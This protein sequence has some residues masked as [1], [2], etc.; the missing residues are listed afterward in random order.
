MK[1]WHQA[2]TALLLV[3][4][5]AY[6]QAGREPEQGGG[7]QAQAQAGRGGQGQGG[8]AQGGRG[9]RGGRGQGGGGGGVVSTADLTVVDGWGRPLT[10]PLGGK[11]PGPAPDRN[12][13][14]MWEPADGPG[15]GIQANGPSSMPSDG[16]SEP[17]YTPE[18][19]KVYDSHKALY[20]YR[21][22]LPSM[23]NDPR[24]NCDPLGMPRANFYQLRHTQFIQ[25]PHQVVVLYQFDR[26]YRHIWTDGRDFPKELPDNRWYGYSIGRWADPATF[27]VNT[28]GLIGNERVWLDETG[29]PMSDQMKVEERFHRVNSHR[30][31]ITVTVDDPKYYSRPWV[32][33]DKF[34]MK[35]QANDYDIIEMLCAPSDMESYKTDFADPAS[36]IIK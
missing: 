2:A 11:A 36:G 25:L 6:V 26:R 10:D 33:M 19:K 29:R 17:P 22:V 20:G 1:R 5:V 4:A 13:A 30:L 8:A 12:I 31:E 14:G 24:N 16:K 7:G 32:P 18:G 15:A 23:S 35:L 34:P 3:S 27:V 9:G 21:A 28:I